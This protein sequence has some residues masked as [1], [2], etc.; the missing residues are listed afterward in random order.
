MNL[1]MNQISNAPESPPNTLIKPMAIIGSIFSALIGAAIVYVFGKDPEFCN[2]F[3]LCVKTILT[4][5]YISLAGT[6]IASG[7]LGAVGGAA[8]GFVYNE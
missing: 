8:F 7:I 6:V 4:H 2:K 1:L 5:P 3:D